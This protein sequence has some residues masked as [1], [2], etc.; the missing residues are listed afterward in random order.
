MYPRGREIVL[1]VSGGISAYKS[2]DLLRRLQDLGFLVTVIPTRASLNFVGLSSWEAL[3]GRLVPT[4]LW[5][6]VHQVPHIALAREADAIVVAP[7][8][9]DI[10]A[11]VAAGIADDLLTNVILASKVPL[12]FVPAM[13]T[14]MWLNAA[15][16]ANV[17][18]LRSRG[19]QVIEPDSGK[20]TSGDVGLGRYPESSKIIAC[21][22]STLQ[23]RADLQGRTVLISTGGTREAIDPVRFIGNNSSGRQGYALAYAAIARGATVTLVAANCALEDI[24]GV[25]T[26]HVTTALEM[27][28]ALESRFDGADVVVMAAAVADVRPSVFNATKIAKDDLSEIPVIK[29]PDITKELSLRKKNQIMIGFAAQTVDSVAEGLALA[30]AKMKDKGLDIVYFNDVSGGAIF[31]S[32]KTAGVILTSSGAKFEFASGPKVTLANKILDLAVDKLGYAND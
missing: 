11:K 23:S 9:A 7:A 13:H 26:V 20:L 2:C 6:N 1:G 10:M 17:Q 4:D 8:T 25:E 12:I 27:Q 14:E 28:A 5:N 30:A 22:T 31:G 18:L 29:N 32:D 19:H 21:L 16:Q 3:S 24:E 15:T